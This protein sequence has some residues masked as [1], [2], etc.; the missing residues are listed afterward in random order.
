M[1]VRG[2]EHQEIGGR[3]HRLPGAH[4]DIEK[5]TKKYFPGNVGDGRGGERK[6][7]PSYYRHTI[8]KLHVYD[9]IF[10][11]TSEFPNKKGIFDINLV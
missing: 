8:Q 1:A 11:K 2:V 6:L 4:L 9:Q 3:G 5:G 10:L 7:F